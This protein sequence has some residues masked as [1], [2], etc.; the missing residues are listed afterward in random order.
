MNMQK[1]I[2]FFNKKTHERGELAK[3]KSSLLGSILKEQ[4]T[5]RQQSKAQI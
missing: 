1:N 5:L 2:A 3:N 4:M